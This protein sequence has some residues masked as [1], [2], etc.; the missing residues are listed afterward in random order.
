MEAAL[1]AARLAAAR[2]NNNSSL[3]TINVPA[4]NESANAENG[5]SAFVDDEM[6]DLEL[7]NAVEEEDQDQDMYYVDSNEYAYQNVDD[8]VTIIADDSTLA[9]PRIVRG[10]T[11]IDP[12]DMPIPLMS[13]TTTAPFEPAPTVVDTQH[14][15]LSQQQPKPKLSKIKADLRSVLIKQYSKLI[16][17]A[18]TCA[19]HQAQTFGSLDEQANEARKNFP[20]KAFAGPDA[21]YRFKGWRQ[22]WGE[23]PASFE[24]IEYSYMEELLD[25]LNKDVVRIRV[26]KSKKKSK[27]RKTNH[28]SD[29]QERNT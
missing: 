3:A 25:K 20:W 6:E 4:E 19:L 15:H 13:T 11:A 17:D 5:E 2:I 18:N 14:V 21:K 7:A 10:V 22:R 1:N 12:N 29:A 23:V 28:N 24:D 9:I 8:A 26:K 27:K 16:D